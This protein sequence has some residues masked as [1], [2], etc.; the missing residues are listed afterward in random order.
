VKDKRGRLVSCYKINSNCLYGFQV[1][2]TTGLKSC[3]KNR[4]V[5]FFCDIRWKL[6]YFSYFDSRTRGCVYYRHKCTLYR[7]VEKLEVMRDILLSSVDHRILVRYQYFI[8][9]PYLFHLQF[10][11]VIKKKATPGL[12]TA[13]RCTRHFRDTSESLV[14]FQTIFLAQFFVELF[15]ANTIM[16]DS[17]K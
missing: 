2:H 17:H 15:E 13:K 6:R 9:I 3:L 10:S 7:Y 16:D 12:A 1:H 14:S 5:L 8:S 11:L 4:W